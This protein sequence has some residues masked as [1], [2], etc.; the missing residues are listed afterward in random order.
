MNQMYSIATLVLAASTFAQTAAKPRLAELYVD[1]TRNPKYVKVDGVWEPDNPTKQNELV[2]TVV[3]IECY[4]HGGTEFVGSDP[5]CLVASATPVA[6]SINV[7]ANWLKV[8]EW[9]TREIITLDDSPICLTSQN[10][11][12]LT[13]KTVVGMDIRK[14]NARGFQDSCKLL[15]DRQTY[16]LRDKVDY[17][18][19]H[20]PVKK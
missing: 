16:F 10:T 2:F 5:F 6:L 1:D 20:A 14:P 11:F 13:S 3:S 7:D 4:K 18:L 9:N 15:P 17:A 12:D 8:I 19:N